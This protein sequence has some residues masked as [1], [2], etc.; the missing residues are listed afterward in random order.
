MTALCQL[1]RTFVRR[2]KYS[3]TKYEPIS[4]DGMTSRAQRG[5]FSGMILRPR[6]LCGTERPSRKGGD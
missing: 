1:R 4:R 2:I 6:R 3:I 5:R